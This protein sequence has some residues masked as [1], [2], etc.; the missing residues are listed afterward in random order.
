MTG[1][2]RFVVNS[3]VSCLLDHDRSN[4]KLYNK[5]KGRFYNIKTCP[6]FNLFQIVDVEHFNVAK[7]IVSQGVEK[8]YKEPLNVQGRRLFQECL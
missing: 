1:D 3:G 6:C 5:N 8:F 2:N 7:T 4:C